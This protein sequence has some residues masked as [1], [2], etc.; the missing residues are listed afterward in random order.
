MRLIGKLLALPFVL[1]TGI[2]YLV[3]KFL[4]VISGAVLGILSGIVFL[5]AL[6]L[7][8]RY[9]AARRKHR[10]KAVL[11]LLLGIVCAV[12]GVVLYYLGMYHEY[13]TIRDFYQ[14]RLSGWI[15]FGIVALLTL[16]SLVRAFFAAA[17]ARREEKA[18]I[19]AE[20]QRLA[21]EAAAAEAAARDAARQQD[22]APVSEP[23]A[24][25]PDAAA[26]APQ[27]PMPEPAEPTA[28]PETTDVSQV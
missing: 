14:I 19:R 28:A 11:K 12:G 15:G 9:F 16:A 22:A 10:F 5:A 24:P 20:N 23:P 7:I 6:V 21:A 1:V 2:L 25:V 27:E 18:A 26:P 8:I 13:F 17:D 4:V 3:C